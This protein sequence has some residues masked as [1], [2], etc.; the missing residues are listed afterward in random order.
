MLAVATNPCP[1]GHYGN[2]NN[3]C[4]C[5][6][7]A[8]NSYR[9]RISGPLLD[10][11][12]LHVDVPPL[13]HEE[14]TGLPTGEPSETI[15]KRVNRARSVQL[16]RFQNFP[17]LFSNAQMESRHIRQFCAIDSAGLNIMKMAIQKLGLSA[18][19]YDRVL[20]VSRTIADMEASEN[21][22]PAH[23]CEA[24]QYRSLDRNME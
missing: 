22:L 6:D 11:I 19:A 23:L 14:I 18:R 5:T 13:R 20:K 12:D 24:I 21:I 1:C 15:R 16:A 10:R 9:A 4:T 2:D 17:G 3:A 8:I 7:F